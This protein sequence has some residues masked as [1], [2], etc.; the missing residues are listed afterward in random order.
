MVLFDFGFS[1]NWMDISCLRPYLYH[2]HHSICSEHKG[3]GE[4]SDLK[5]GLTGKRI[6]EIC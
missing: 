3:E 2:F 1:L 5:R 4:T 6:E